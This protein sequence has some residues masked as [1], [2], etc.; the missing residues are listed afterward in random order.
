MSAGAST[1]KISIRDFKSKFTKPSLTSQY[2]CNFAVNGHTSSFLRQRGVIIGNTT[3]YDNLSILCCNASLPGSS[4]TTIDVENDHHGVSNKHAYRRLYDDRADFTFYVDGSNY[5]VI[6]FFENWIGYCV[7]E[8]YG[9][10]GEQYN[11]RASDYS[12]RVNYPDL[13][14][15][16][17]LSITKFEKDVG[18][19]EVAGS[20]LSNLRDTITPG[21]PAGNST[22]QYN[23]VN[24][25][26]ISIFS[27]PLS[28]ESSQLL[29]CTVSF[30]YSRYWI[31]SLAVPQ[32]VSLP[33]PNNSNPEGNVVTP[34]TTTTDGR[35]L[36][37]SL[38]GSDT[39][40]D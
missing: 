18:V 31:N 35:P 40:T 38:P 34:P 3:I 33:N 28:Y 32:S 23:F 37:V 36:E 13:Y 11:I 2:V 15:T 14:V 39:T 19:G 26:P 29:K 22:L 25:F 24:A 17:N 6:R 30:S 10:E 7:N 12:Y 27:M 16:E 5:F 20:D 21:I 4:L 9:R 8:Q 1:K